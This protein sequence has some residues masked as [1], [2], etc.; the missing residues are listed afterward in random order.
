MKQCKKCGKLKPRTEFYE[1]TQSWCKECM[2]KYSHDKEHYK[3]SGLKSKMC[4]VCKDVHPLVDF[5]AL[6]N[7]KYGRVCIHC[8]GKQ[9]GKQLEMIIPKQSKLKQPKAKP[10]EQPTTEVAPKVSVLTK[11]TDRLFGRKYY[12]NI[13]N[14]VGTGKCEASC[15]IFPTLEMAIS[16]KESLKFNRSYQ[17]VE[18]ISF[19]TKKQYKSTW[20][21]I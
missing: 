3:R 2:K 20:R 11:I 8:Q 16:H 13:I 9:D 17:Y 6:P 5:T 18:T 21:S 7:G 12:I 1:S 15:F 4:K 19:R 10:M 14:L